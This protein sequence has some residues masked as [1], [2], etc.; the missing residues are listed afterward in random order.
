MTDPQVI[1]SI[2]NWNGCDKTLACLESLR[3]LDYR[4]HQIIVVDN[5]SR[6]DSV[7]RIRAA[8]PEIEL[9]CT[10]TN[11]GFSGGHQ[12]AL[13]H[14]MQRGANLFWMLNNDTR[15]R[16]DTLSAL[17]DAYRRWGEALYGS[18]SVSDDDQSRLE[19]G[20]GWE[21]DPQ[22]KPD[23]SIYNRFVGM[24]YDEYLAQWP[25]R[26]VA[27]LSGSSLMVPLSVIRQYGFFDEAF[28]FYAEDADYCLRLRK[29]GIPSVIVPESVIMHEKHGSFEGNSQL[30]W[31]RTY[32]LRRNNTVAIRRYQGQRAYWR[33]IGSELSFCTRAWFSSI[34]RTRKLGIPVRYRDRYLALRDVLL[35]RMGKTIA[36]EDY[37]D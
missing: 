9:L 15:V 14:V 25:Q 29:K 2:L 10:D 7:A 8:Y 32:Y 27:T 20:G 35:H 37:L 1:I 3:A 16:P 21:L 17:A 13:D 12:F 6:D 36:P 26:A 28:F 18:V 5:H 4:H 23:F 30:D 34:R 22:G 11:L 31:V 24:L 33:L 19:Y